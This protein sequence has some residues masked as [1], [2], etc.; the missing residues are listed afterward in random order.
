MGLR[1]NN[2]LR[3]LWVVGAALGIAAAAVAAAGAVHMLRLPQPPTGGVARCCS[4]SPT[5][6]LFVQ[7]YWA[8]ALWTFIQQFLMQCFFLQRFLRVFSSPR[9]AALATAAIF[10]LAHLPNPI[11]APVTLFW[12]LATCLLFLRYR[13]LYPLAMA[14]AIFGIAISI[15]VPAPLLHNMRV[16]LGYLRYGHSH[17]PI[18]LSQP[19]GPDRVH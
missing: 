13:N 16:G 8:Y 11:L 18:Q 14:H 10:A 19:Q 1:G 9:S 6:T 3:S 12:G 4:L 2:F 17:N 15:A 5:L 7:T